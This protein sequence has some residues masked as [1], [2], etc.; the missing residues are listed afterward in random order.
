MA[1]DVAGGVGELGEHQH[2]A[3]DQVF[4]AKQPGELFELVVLGRGE[5]AG[6]VEELAYLV[7]V[8]EH[9]VH[10][11]GH[12]VLVAGQLPP[13]GGIE[14][15]LGNHI[16]VDIF[17]IVFAAEGQPELAFGVVAD[18]R[19]V[20][21]LPAV[22]ALLLRIGLAV[23]LHEGQEF[24]QQQVERLLEG[25]HRA[26][27]PLE[28]HGA[29]EAHH[30]ALAV[31]L[32]SVNAV[33]GAAV[34]GQRVIEGQGEERALLLEGLLEQVEHLAVGRPN[35][36]LG[37]L[38]RAALGKRGRLPTLLDLAGLGVGPA[39]LHHQGPENLVTGQGFPG[40]WSVPVGD[41]EP[42]AA[43]GL[44]KLALHDVEVAGEVVNAQAVG[45][46]GV[47]AQGEQ[48]HHMAEVGQAVVDRRGG[49]HEHLF[50]AR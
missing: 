33:V 35:G 25:V 49:E 14:Q 10:D 8:E 12:V 47:V 23:N 36:V 13:G 2:L 31:L 29:D 39:A 38:G 45:E 37:H 18:H 46:V 7:E 30:L 9:L 43:Q 1:G 4:A 21:A 44:L 3:V 32:K 22:V 6:E 19:G 15:F 20:L 34:V 26:L 48:L 24:A 42:S 16:L 50:G 41:G 27:E 40:L 11:L 17:L 28:E 5:P